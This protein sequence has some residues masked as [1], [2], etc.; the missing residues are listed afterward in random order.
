MD[1]TEHH[2][3]LEGWE[4]KESRAHNDAWRGSVHRKDRPDLFSTEGVSVA[5]DRDLLELLAQ[6]AARLASEAL[7]AGRARQRAQRQREAIE[8]EIAFLLQQKAA[9]EATLRSEPPSWL[10]AASA[11]LRAVFLAAA[12]NNWD[13]MDADPVSP[14]I[15]RDASKLLLQL[16]HWVPRPECAAEADG[17]LTLGWYLAQ[18]LTFEVSVGEGATLFFAG[19]FGTSRNHGVEHLADSIPPLVAANLQRLIDERARRTAAGSAKH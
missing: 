16:P 9:L 6:E 10:Q 13:D 3:P 19:L 12:A 7:E 4:T 15:Y 2:D 18:D 5:P 14:T 8:Q 1:R 17:L 11:E